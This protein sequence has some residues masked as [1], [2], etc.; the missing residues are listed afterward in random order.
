VCVFF[1]AKAE[2]EKHRVWRIEEKGDKH[3]RPAFMITSARSKLPPPTG[4]K[5]QVKVDSRKMNKL[6]VKVAPRRR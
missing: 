4:G 6:A 3:S 5:H 2:S 1:N